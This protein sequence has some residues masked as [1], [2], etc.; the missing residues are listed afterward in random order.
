MDVSC[1]GS[2]ATQRWVFWTT[3]ASL[4]A[5]TLMETVAM[6]DWLAPSLARYV[7]ASVPLKSES[8]VYRN[9]PSAF[10]E[11]VPWEGPPTMIAVRASPS[12]SVSLTSTP[13]FGTERAWSSLVT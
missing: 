1:A 11:R 4:T 7:N 9:E 10:S 2:V 5:P 8:G 13:A 3:G 12:T 6:S